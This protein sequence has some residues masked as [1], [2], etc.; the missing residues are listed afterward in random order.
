M[1]KYVYT[2]MNTEPDA[3]L[4][5]AK[6]S[7][8]SAKKEGYILEEA[9]SI[10]IQAWVYYHRRET[11]KSFLHYLSAI[12]LLRPLTHKKPEADL[13]S[14]LLSN[15]GDLVVEHHSTEDAINFYDE[16]ILIA[17]RHQ[18]WKRLT[19]L[20]LNKAE[21][22][23]KEK[24]PNSAFE[25]IEMALNYVKKF[26]D[27]ELLAL[28]MNEKGLIESELKLT[29]SAITTFQ[30]ILELKLATSISHYH[31]GKAW[32]N[33]GHIYSEKGEMYKSMDAFLQSVK[34][35][36]HNKDKTQLF[37]TWKN[38]CELHILQE[39]WISA[40][41]YGNKAISLYE[42]VTVL[43]ENYRIF[44]YMSSIYFENGDFI[45]SHEYA[46]K[47]ISENSRF[48]EEQE[49]MIQ[50][51]DQ[52]KMEL[53]TAG[54]FMESKRDKNESI[55]FTII[56]SIVS[57]FTIVLIAGMTRQYYIKQSIKRSLIDL[58]LDH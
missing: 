35:K 49:K 22:L 29:D 12:E 16:G 10:F 15:I 24:R 37:I 9:N 25:D 19:Y 27:I 58:N 1:H 46:Q 38:I 34:I 40:L 2:I 17:T 7:E 43:P 20:H 30:S 28:C 6:E 52:Y 53:L 26:G 23:R 33:I 18:L 56:S 57:L 48:L 45:K 44:E 42:N 39:N 47:F 5:L 54:F 13:L 51:K 4:K 3:A 32:H 55:Y 41:E 36:S 11:G 50:V 21:L 14:L 8:Q 31:Y